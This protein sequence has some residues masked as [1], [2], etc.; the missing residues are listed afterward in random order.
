M[1]A[2]SA[3][4]PRPGSGQVLD[5]ATRADTLRAASSVSARASKPLPIAWSL[6]LHRAAMGPLRPLDAPD[7]QPGDTLLERLRRLEQ[8]NARLLDRERTRLEE[9]RALAGIGRLLSE[10]LPAPR[11]RPRHAGRPRPPPAR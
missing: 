6:L 10:R 8:D 11:G 5:F 4:P 1:V 7:L 9:T 3:R 2:P